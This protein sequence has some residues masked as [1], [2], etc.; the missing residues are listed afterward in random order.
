MG[1][2]F[3]KLAFELEQS[4]PA[5]SPFLPMVGLSKQFEDVCSCG[6]PSEFGA[7]GITANV[8]YDEYFCQ[9]CW[10]KRKSN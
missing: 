10:N 8:I 7:H 9:N 4:M 2:G 6:L 3:D 1:K 5:D